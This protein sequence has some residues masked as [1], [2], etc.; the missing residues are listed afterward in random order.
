MLICM[1]ALNVLVLDGQ[2][3]FGVAGGFD[4]NTLKLGGQAARSMDF[5]QTAAEAHIGLGY[6]QATFDA[7]EKA[8]HHRINIAAKDRLMRAA[9]ARIT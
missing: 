2:G 3:C 8:C 1:Q 9:H 6:G 7:I 5:N 4:F